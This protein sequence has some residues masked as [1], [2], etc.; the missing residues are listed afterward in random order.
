MFNRVSLKISE[1][2]DTLHFYYYNFFIP[3]LQSEALGH[4]SIDTSS[5]TSPPTPEDGKQ[6]R[7]SSL[8]MVKYMLMVVKHILHAITK[9]AQVTFW[10][11]KKLFLKGV[12]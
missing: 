11:V 2:S 9:M 7:H 1:V 3:S 6:F 4:E 10:Q 12:T 8:F 5:L